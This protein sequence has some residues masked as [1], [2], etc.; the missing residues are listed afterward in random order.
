M[1][2]CASAGPNTDASPSSDDSSMVVLYCTVHSTLL[3]HSVC[4]QPATCAAFHHVWRMRARAHS[5][6]LNL[7]PGTS[8][9]IPG[10]CND[11]HSTS[12][13]QGKTT[14][15]QADSRLCVCMSAHV[16]GGGGAMKQTSAGCRITCNLTYRFMAACPLPTRHTTHTLC[17]VGAVD[18]P[19]HHARPWHT[20]CAPVTV[21]NVQVDTASTVGL[22]HVVAALHW[23]VSQHTGQLTSTGSASNN[24]AGA[25]ECRSPT[26]SAP[27]ADLDDNTVL[28]TQQQHVPRCPTPQ[29]S[30]GARRRTCYSTPAMPF[31]VEVLVAGS[32][33]TSLL[34]GLL[35]GEAPCRCC[36]QSKQVLLTSPK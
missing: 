29:H 6:P 16:G 21:S 7:P 15:G 27:L 2:P 8:T 18:Q 36:S 10:T 34:L 31:T 4:M 14:S 1:S 25:L 11:Q 24:G 19:A 35:P 23:A 22:Q 13:E 30:T 26:P 33:N 20:C 5:K 28:L 12:H 9:A 3:V 32:C 17:E